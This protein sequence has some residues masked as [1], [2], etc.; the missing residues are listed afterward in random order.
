MARASIAQAYVQVVPTTE[1][2]GKKLEDEFKPVA[3]DTGK[4]FGGFFNKALR[5]TLAVGAAITTTALAGVGVAVTKGFGRLTAIENAQALLRGIGHDADSVET[6]MDNA[7]QSVLGTAFGLDDAAQA[8]AMA[9]AAGIEP[10]EDLE[11]VLGVIADT[12]AVAGVPLADIGDIMGKVITS[13]RAY[14]SELQRLAQRGIPIYQM[15]AD[16]LGVTADEVFDMASRGEIDANMLADALEDNLGGAALSMGETVEGSMANVGASIS[17]IGAGLIGGVFAALPDFFGNV[18]E[19]LKP[20]EEVAKDLGAELAVALQPAMEKL[21]D[22]LPGLL[23]GALPLVPVL[24]DLLVLFLELAVKALPFIV[25]AITN[26]ITFLTSLASFIIRNRVALIGWGIALG[27]FVTLLGVFAIAAKIKAA[28][29]VLALAKAFAVARIAQIKLTIAM[30]GNPIG[31]LIAAIAALVAGL[32]YFFTQTELGKQVLESIFNWFKGVPDALRAFWGGIS[33]FFSD[34]WHGI[35][36]AFSGLREMIVDGLNAIGDAIDNFATFIKEGAVAIV[37]GLWEG[38]KAGWQAVA[39][40][41]TNM[42]KVVVNFLRNAGRWLINIGRSVIDGLWSGIQFVWRT[43]TTFYTTM[44][45]VILGWLSAAGTWLI[46]TGRNIIDGMWNGLKAVWATVTGWFNGLRNIVTGLLSNAG[47]WLRNIGRQVIDG[48]LNG[49]KG[50]WSAVTSWISGAAERVSGAFR[51]IL[52]I[53]SPS[54]V[55][56]EFGENIGQ[57][58]I[59]GMEKIQPS[60]DSE[61]RSLVQVPNVGRVVGDSANT[62]RATNITYVAAPNQSLTS[63]QELIK[64]MRRARLVTQW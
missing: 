51:N 1:G 9:V 48:F 50:A 21:V 58:L 29:G 15:L 22:L 19:A 7:L 25:D 49:L 60:V 23:T 63:E 61:V 18:I 10:G 28:G 27:T 5:G 31:I 55:F 33:G 4:G 12:A 2:I 39:N 34:L 14:N 17:R 8:A 41:F 37:T 62:N 43:V 54:R 56:M 20:F 64:A 13:N 53:S 6:I 3:D 44:G 24:A 11:R 35:T 59:L 38:I 57:G 45:S 30:L 47:E 16:Q 40:F 52:G 46:N 42:G 26:V 32:I 36:V